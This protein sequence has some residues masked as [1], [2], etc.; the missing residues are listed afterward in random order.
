MKEAAAAVA[1]PAKERS[2]KE[3]REEARERERER[4]R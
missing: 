4:H 3:M 1:H 2:G